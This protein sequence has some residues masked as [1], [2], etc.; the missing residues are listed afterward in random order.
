[1]TDS[2]SQ[3]PQHQQHHNKW[4]LLIAVYKLA[5]AMLFVSIGEG[6][7]HLVHKDIGDILSRLA[8]H[9]PESRLVDFLL[10][11][12]SLLSDPLLR[13]IGVAA[14]FY[15][16]LSVVEGIGLY[17]EKA[18]GEYLTLVITASFLPWE[19]FEM[20]RRV[21]WIRSGLL[22]VNAL[23]FFYLLNLV[24]ERGRRKNSAGNQQADE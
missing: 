18:W 3:S 14:F 22:L 16:A 21:T 12:A 15:A 17:L 6:A 9:L 23:V 10:D 8:D 5:M 19:V 11:K 20:L 13:R 1:M 24:T 7:L 4:L 2:T